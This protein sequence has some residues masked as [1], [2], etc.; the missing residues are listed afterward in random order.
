M[1]RKLI[2]LVTATVALL[3][4]S[5]QSLAQNGPP[6]DY[7]RGLGIHFGYEVINSTELPGGNVIYACKAPYTGN[8]LENGNRRINHSAGTQGDEGFDRAYTIFFTWND[9]TCSEENIISYWPDGDP[10]PSE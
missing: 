6:S 1:I 5:A 10:L 2:Y 8:G 7:K 9:P 3:G 4:L